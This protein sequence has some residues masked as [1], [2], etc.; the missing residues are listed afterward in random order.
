[1][2]DKQ[3]HNITRTIKEAMYIRV[4][5]PSINRNISRFQLPHISDEVLQDT[6][7]FNLE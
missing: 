7:A 6:P 2:V 5:D 1:M 3:V 4:N